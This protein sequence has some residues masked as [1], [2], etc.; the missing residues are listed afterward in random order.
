MATVL[1]CTRPCLNDSRSQDPRML[2]GNM[3]RKN[4]TDCSW[5]WRTSQTLTGMCCTG[6][7]EK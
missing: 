2:T 7:E 1:N 3:K 6:D 5:M 4:R